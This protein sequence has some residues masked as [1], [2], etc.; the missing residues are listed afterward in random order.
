M[1]SDDLQRQERLIYAV[2]AEVAQ[3]PEFFAA[4]VS[5][6]NLGQKDHIE[7]LRN[8]M[9]ELDRGWLLALCALTANRV[10]PGLKNQ[11][12]AA[13]EPIL[14]RKGFGSCAAEKDA[15]K[16]AKAAREEVQ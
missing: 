4:V 6:A 8:R 14:S 9:S 5:A 7:M 12:L 1:N 11:L 13:L 15:L 16:L 3:N 10:T 2:R